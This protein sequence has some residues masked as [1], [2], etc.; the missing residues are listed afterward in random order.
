MNEVLL[1]LITPSLVKELYKPTTSLLK[2]IKDEIA[3]SFNNGVNDYL[4][5]YISTHRKIKTILHRHEPINFYEI[6]QPLK[7]I[8]K[9]EGKTK[10]ILCGSINHVFWESKYITIIGD[11]GSGKS[12]LMKHLFFNCIEEKLGIPVIIELRDF[13][14]IDTAFED[15]I[16]EK[17]TQNNLSPNKNIF[18][19]ILHHGSFVFLIDGYDEL[20]DEKR[21]NV[22]KQINHFVDIYSNNRFLLTTRPFTSI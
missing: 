17:L 8:P 12:T 22:I 2:G 9:K 18:K 7:L 6:F 5:K 4:N 20:K 13:N 14:R 21:G 3:F 1:K 10:P 15:Y 16:F 19:I 11:A